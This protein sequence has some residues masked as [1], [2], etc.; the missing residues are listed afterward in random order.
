[1]L[2]PDQDALALLDSL[3]FR[4]RSNSMLSPDELKQIEQL[5]KTFIDSPA[6]RTAPSK[7]Q[8]MAA[9]N[10]LLPKGAT[11][12]S[13][14]FNKSHLAGAIYRWTQEAALLSPPSLQPKLFIEMK[15]IKG[16]RKQVDLSQAIFVEEDDGSVAALSIS[17]PTTRRPSSSAEIPLSQPMS[18]FLRDFS[19][20]PN[21]LGQTPLSV[22]TSASSFAR[23]IERIASDQ[24]LAATPDV[25]PGVDGETAPHPR[26]PPTGAQCG[27]VITRGA[28]IISQNST[29]LAY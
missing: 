5:M 19:A 21:R 3:G 18:D 16:S 25:A 2:S 10:A 7:N 6:Q 12:V 13:P 1:M 24:S 27:D 8:M 4:R 28:V 22:A 9:V 23:H 29:S 11:L 17:S 20:T 26:T 14:K 15:F